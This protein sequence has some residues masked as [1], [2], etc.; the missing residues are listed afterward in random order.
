MNALHDL[1]QGFAQSENMYGKG[2]LCVALVVTRHAIEAG[3]PVNPD[4][5]LAK[6]G[7]QVKGLG[8]AAVQAILAEHGISRV[9]AEEGGRT[10]RGSVG[11]M[12]NYVA[13]L[14]HLPIKDN[15]DLKDMERWWIDRV[16][17]FFSS[18]PFVLKADTK[19]AVRHCLRH[20][21]SQAQQ[22]QSEATGTMFFGTM[23][24]H[25]IGAKLTLLGISIVHHGASVADQST[26]RCADF[27][28]DDVAIHVTTSPSESLIRKCMRNLDQDLRPLIITTNRHVPV[29]D[30][31]AESLGI[32]DRLDIFDAEQFLTSNIFELGMFSQAGRRMKVRELV[33]EY[34]R[35]VELAETDPSLRIRMG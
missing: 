30:A 13:F 22:R 35:I 14:N 8:K 15:D 29:A 3:L 19:M 6:S 4:E 16:R 12:R 32:A 10:S 27:Q 2:S 34:N 21:L 11:N 7:G 26:E 1:L 5:M 20:L 31:M 24:Q 17:R 9:L 25:L 23:L 28:V 18:K 33:E